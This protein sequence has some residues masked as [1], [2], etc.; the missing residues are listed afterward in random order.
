MAICRRCG[1]DTPVPAHITAGRMR[2]RSCGES[3]EIGAPERPTQRLSSGEGGGMVR[4]R[5]PGA[6]GSVAA[7]ASGA[8]RAAPVGL[9][10]TCPACRERYPAERGTTCPACG[11]DGRAMREALE[12]G[13]RDDDGFGPERAGIRAGVLGGVTMLVIACI[14]GFV[15]YYKLGIIFYYPPVLAALGVFALAK[16]LAD[17]NL[18]GESHQLPRRRRIR[19]R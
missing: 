13:G 1:N 10:R 16:G 12:G 6:D 11:T 4:A 2:C 17:G 15:G 18:A 3:V 14:W 7:G 5:M 8:S 9:Q 19:R